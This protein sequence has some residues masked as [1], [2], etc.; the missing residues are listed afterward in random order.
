MKKYIIPLLLILLGCDDFGDINT[1]PNNPTQVP[2]SGFLANAI[3]SLPGYENGL[4][5]LYYSQYWAATQYTENSRYDVSQFDFTGIYS[6]PLNALE[7]VIDYNSNPETMAFAAESGSN[8][9]QIAVAKI[10]QSHFFIH[11]T[12]RW[13][14]LPYSEALK[15]SEN[16]APAYDTQE[17]IY[18]AIFDDLD[19]AINQFDNGAA[20]SGDILYNGDIEKWKKF[21]NSLKLKMAIRIS[22]IAPEKARQEFEEA[23]SDGVFTSNADGA[24][25][26][27]L[28]D[29]VFDNPRY[30]DFLTRI[31]NAVSKELTDVLN[32]L[33]DPRLKAYA[34][35]INPNEPDTYEGIPF[36][37][38]NSAASDYAYDEVSLPNSSLVISKAAEIP[39][40]T[41]S[42]VLFFLAEGAEKG[43]NANGSASEHYNEAIKASM[44]Q[45]GVFDQSI[46]DDY[47][48]HADVKYESE[49]AMKLIGTQK[50][51][52]TYLQGY[53]AWAEWRRLG[54]PELLPAPAALNN[55]GE[56]P[57][58]QGY[59]SSE[60]QNNAANYEAAVSRQGPDDLD[61]SVWW[62]TE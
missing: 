9:N 58:R 21:A 40:L 62:D 48:N 16:L 30:D 59:P 60:S 50:W 14:D 1:D 53:E 28:G 52:A 37:L 47:I 13:G 11:A 3:H 25:Y 55:S 26:Q 49:N 24:F 6:G 22:N 5:G 34:D 2:V 54:Y 51:I 18:N 57:R 20:P 39:I 56:I 10:L 27:Y 32:N 8:A 46:Y 33:N 31:D 29:G 43:W 7:T 23:V 41:Y 19:E 44:E 42:Q 17:D 35:P 15:G 36:G 38:D 61:T 4:T 12:D 45:W